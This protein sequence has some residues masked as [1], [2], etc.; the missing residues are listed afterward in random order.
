MKCQEHEC[1]MEWVESSELAIPGFWW[2]EECS[3]EEEGI[4]EGYEDDDGDGPDFWEDSLLF[5]S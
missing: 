2:C 5:P 1:D 3:R 4:E